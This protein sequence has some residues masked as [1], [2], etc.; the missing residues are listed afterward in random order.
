MKRIVLIVFVLYLSPIFSQ[1][2]DANLFQTWYLDFV[3]VSDNSQEFVT[4]NY[5]LEKLPSL[6]IKED[7]SFTGFGICN[8][9]VGK[10]KM[11]EDIQHLYVSEFSSSENSCKENLTPLENEYFSFIR[12]ANH[13]SVITKNN[14][15]FLQLSTNVFGS[16]EFSNIVLS[17]KSEKL[18]KIAIRF[19]NAFTSL[20]ITSNKL[21][22]Q[23]VELFNTVGK[24]IL[25]TTQDFENIVLENIAVG[26]FIL[27][28]YTKA[29][30][31][32]KKILKRE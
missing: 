7:L 20:H 15:Q 26:I 29:G 13:P 17:T 21:Q 32:N 22:I 28:I 18:K 2:V 9:F 11:H 12:H 23:K 4:S 30:V 24:K 27:R 16:A 31:L 1:E 19:E 10:F 3:T 6:T 25:S 14:T 8:S 5:N